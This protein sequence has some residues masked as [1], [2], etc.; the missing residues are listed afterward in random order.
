MNV[1]TLKAD[2]PFDGAHGPGAASGVKLVL[3]NGEQLLISWEPEVL[4]SFRAVGP[5]LFHLEFV[6]KQGSTLPD[7]RSPQLPN[8]N[9]AEKEAIFPIGILPS[10]FPTAPDDDPS[11]SFR[12]V[13]VGYKNDGIT[14]AGKA[15]I[16]SIIIEDVVEVSFFQV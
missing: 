10:D 8:L 13:I 3:M 11:S 5:Q 9:G 15:I 1:I 4:F 2:K 6:D 7:L 14:V 12:I 16:D